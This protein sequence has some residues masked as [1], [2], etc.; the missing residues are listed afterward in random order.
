[1]KDIDINYKR[2]TAL[3]FCVFSLIIAIFLLVVLIMWYFPS[4]WSLMILLREKIP[5][6]G[7][8]CWTAIN[9]FLIGLTFVAVVLLVIRLFWFFGKGFVYL[10]DNETDQKINP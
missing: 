6:M 4:N 1:M 8:R 9:P 10:D 3:F 2:L 5:E 7:Q